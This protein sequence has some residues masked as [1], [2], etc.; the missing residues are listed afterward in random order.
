MNPNDPLVPFSVEPWS[1]ADTRA[2]LTKFPLPSEFTW[3]NRDGIEKP[4][5][6]SYRITGGYGKWLHETPNFPGL[7]ELVHGIIAR[8]PFGF[9]ITPTWLAAELQKFRA[10]GSQ[11][12]LF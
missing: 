5:L 3:P 11:T 2:F 7:F 4:V 8:A 6:P 10:T 1:Q 9:V 12:S